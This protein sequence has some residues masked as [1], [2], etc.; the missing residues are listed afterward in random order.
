[1][2]DNVT[3]AI[4]VPSVS[5]GAL[6]PCI[7]PQF[8]AQAMAFPVVGFGFVTRGYIPVIHYPDRVRSRWNRFP[9]KTKASAA[10]AFAY[11]ER[12]IHYRQIRAAAK[13]RRAELRESPYSFLIAAE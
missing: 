4:P 3:T 9:R 6:R 10:E 1:M 11:A 2:A 7:V 8:T 12:A 13:R 5:P